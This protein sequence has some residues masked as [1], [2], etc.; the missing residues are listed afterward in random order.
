MDVF[1]VLHHSI[2]ET[3]IPSKPSLDMLISC[4]CS[5]TPFFKHQKCKHIIA[6]LSVRKVDKTKV[7]E[8]PQKYKRK[9]IER[10]LNRGRKTL[11]Q[12]ALKRQEVIITELKERKK[13]REEEEEVRNFYIEQ[14]TSARIENCHIAMDM[15]A[16]VVQSGIVSRESDQESIG[17]GRG[18]G[19][20][21]GLIEKPSLDDHRQGLKVLSNRKII[22]N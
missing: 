2:I 9:N 18:R 22:I 3:I 8:I 12:L 16:E 6:H 19:R 10:K 1:N 14:V 11:A 7:L 17:R 20:G 15:E 4:T 13:Q 5:C 21:R